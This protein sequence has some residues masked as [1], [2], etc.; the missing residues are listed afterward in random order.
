MDHAIYQRLNR[1]HAAIGTAEECDPEKYRATV[2][3]NEKFVA[4]SQDFRGGLSEDEIAN[5]AHSVI[6]NIAKLRDHLRRWAVNNSQDKTK[7]DRA[8]ESCFELKVIQDLS[9]NDKHGY[10]PRDGGYS[11]RSPQLTEIDRVMRLQTQARKGSSIA[12]F[13]GADSVPRFFGDGTA[14]AIVTGN[15]VDNSNNPIG[16]LHE[17]ANRA[18]EA[19]ERLL[20]DFGFTTAQSIA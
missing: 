7:V 14:K 1:I 9:N 2:I 10:P 11:N 3:Q 20:V 8:I 15:V 13:L 18:I 19:W 6:D 5:Q 17:I 16:D 4:I 12:M